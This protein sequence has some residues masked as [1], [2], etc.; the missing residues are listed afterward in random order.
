[1]PITANQIDI[2]DLRRGFSAPVQEDQLDVSDFAFENSHRDAENSATIDGLTVRNELSVSVRSDIASSFTERLAP[3]VS[4][5]AKETS[6]KYEPI[7]PS[8]DPLDDENDDGW[9]GFDNQK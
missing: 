7:D 3:L 6:I 9:Y 5:L 8:I 4:I 2:T 1:M